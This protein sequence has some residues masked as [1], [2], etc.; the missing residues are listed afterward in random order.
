MPTY[1]VAKGHSIML[2]PKHDL[3]TAV[4]TLLKEGN[5]IPDGLFSK[6]EIDRK[7]RDGYV[8]AHGMPDREPEASGTVPGRSL[9]Q[10]P[11]D[12][13]SA[14]TI[15]DGTLSSSSSGPNSIRTSVAEKE[16][17]PVSPEVTNDP[18]PWVLNPAGLMDKDLDE[19]R[20]M[21]LERDPDF[22]TD[23]VGTVEEAIEFLSQDFHSEE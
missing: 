11:L 1:R 22:D 9:G 10:D 13:D 18:T 8:V 2:P 5:V 3:P 20:V 6:A 17:N 12:A 4:G 15:S 19:L 23:S 7:I 21:I 16:A 14:P